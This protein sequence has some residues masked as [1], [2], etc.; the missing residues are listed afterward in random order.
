MAYVSFV[1]NERLRSPWCLVGT[2]ASVLGTAR[3]SRFVPSAEGLSNLSCAS[4]SRDSAVGFA[5][6]MSVQ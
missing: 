4:S 6:L 1:W 5:V 3:H 2:S